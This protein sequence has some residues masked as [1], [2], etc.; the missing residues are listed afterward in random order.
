MTRTWRVPVIVALSVGLVGL[1]GLAEPAVASDRADRV[2]AIVDRADPDVMEVVVTRR[3]TDGVPRFETIATPTESDARDVVDEH[4]DA[5]GV[6]SV[7]MN[8]PVQAF[9]KATKKECKKV[10][11]KVCKKD[12][13]QHRNVC[14]KVCANQCRN[15]CKKGRQKDCLRRLQPAAPVAAPVPSPTPMPPP[16][17]PE[18]P[19]PPAPV[20]P[21]DPLFPIQWALDRDHFDIAA[22]D[23]ITKDDTAAVTVAVI[24]SGV[25]AS[26]PDLLGR[27]GAGHNAMSPGTPG[28]DDCGH[29]THVAG[30]IAA[31]TNNG[32]GVAGMART[33]QVVPVKVLDAACNGTA[34]SVA[35]GIVWAADHADVLN[36]SLGSQTETAAER[37]AVDYALS[38]G[39]VVV[40]AAGNHRPGCE[41][42][43]WC[44]SHTTY[45]AAYPGVIGVA[46]VNANGDSAGFSNY[47]D[48]VD[49]AAPGVDIVSTMPATAVF[50]C[51]DDYCE[52]DGTST[53]APHVAALAAMALSHCAWSGQEAADQIVR[54]SSHYPARD[55]ATGYGLIQPRAVVGC[56]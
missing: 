22:L 42:T 9:A 27:V 40:A 7:E 2:E 43:D 33:A 8:Q 46:A 23:D 52:R 44:G 10:C 49:V 30:I 14:K 1:A 37:D 32:I 54:R 25:D 53:A 31:D 39:R 13:K 20:Y 12:P 51:G 50:G 5:P 41:P 48:W 3:D 19:V 29:G 47:G 34:A 36:L 15:V 28:T 17:P 35:A 4:L 18:P 16:G 11:K 6:A 24:D 38:L 45:P 21:D 26:H 55:D 56:G